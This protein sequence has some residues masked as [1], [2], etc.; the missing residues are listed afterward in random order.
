MRELT[1]RLNKVVSKDEA[2]E[3]RAKVWKAKLSAN[4]SFDPRSR[5]PLMNMRA[6]VWGGGGGG[7]G[8][9]GSASPRGPANNP[10]FSAGEP[11]LADA[12]ASVEFRHVVHLYRH[13]IRSHV[14]TDLFAAM[15]A[16]PPPAE[17]GGDAHGLGTIGEGVSIGHHVSA[18]S[19]AIGNLVR[20]MAISSFNGNGLRERLGSLSTSSGRCRSP[21]LLPRSAPTSSSVKHD[22]S[23]SAAKAKREAADLAMRTSSSVKHGNAAAVSSEEHARE[24]AYIHPARSI[25]R[26]CSSHGSGVSLFL[27]TR[28]KLGSTSMLGSVRS[29]GSARLGSEPPRARI[30]AACAPP[31]VDLGPAH[32]PGLRTSH[33]RPP[34]AAQSHPTADVPPASGG[35]VESSAGAPVAAVPLE[36]RGDGSASAADGAASGRKKASTTSGGAAAV[37]LVMLTGGEGGKPPPQPLPSPAPRLTKCSVSSGVSSSGG[38]GSSG[39][40][41]GGATSPTSPSGVSKLG[42]CAKFGVVASRISSGGRLS[43]LAAGVG[44]SEAAHRQ[45]HSASSESTSAI[46]R[47]EEWSEAEFGRFLVERQ[48]EQGLSSSEVSRRFAIAAKGGK[49]LSV[50]DLHE[51]LFSRDNSAMDPVHL[52]VC[53]DMGQ[54]LS[55]YFVESSHNTYATGDQL[56]S[57]SSVDMYKRVLMMGCRCIEIDCFDGPDN[58][59]EVYHKATLTSRIKFRD[60]IHA[61][62]AVGFKASQYP[63]ISTPR[64]PRA[65]SHQPPTCATVTRLQPGPCGLGLLSAA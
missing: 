33:F 34:P 2:T 27:S 54:P 9:S 18:L 4:S 14:I 61:V 3:L 28:A 56:Q 58:E 47:P 7:G 52:E 8:G 38:S 60:V 48:L 25:S 45:R 37:E 59:P 22:T 21:S 64:P 40:G 35:T 11:T 57:E 44:G 46:P 32:S 24:S 10:S 16:A 63:V 41:V 51:W 12:D 31:T 42:R 26:Q 19:Q 17:A 6:S 62:A 55:S 13:L 53:M 50:D 23:S 1:V 49:G 43:T 5:R 29:L 65:A 15:L 36:R 20:P 39:S 30:G